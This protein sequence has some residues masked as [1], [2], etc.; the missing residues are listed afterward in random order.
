MGALMGS[1]REQATLFGPRKSLVG[2]I[3]QDPSAGIDL[4]AVVILNAGIIHR[5]GPHRMFVRLSRLL[6]GQRR[7]VVRF[8][9]SGI[10]DSEPRNDGLAP[11]E[12]ALADLR[13]VLDSLETTRQIK[14]VVLVGLCSGAD[15]SVIYGGSDPRVVGLVLIDPSVPRTWRYYAHHYG[16]RIFRLRSWLNFTT[17]RHPMWRQLKHSIGGAAEEPAAEPADFLQTREVRAFLQN[18]YQRVVNAGIEILAVF[19]GDRESQYNYRE[20]LLEAFPA[21]RFGTLLQLHY[22]EK[23]THTF[24]D[25]SDREALLRLIVEW[26]GARLRGRADAAAGAAVS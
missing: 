6:A 21:V 24:T 23:A 8:D 14:Q 7:T 22:Y 9:L 2:I 19:T 18:A 1:L 26:M 12:A 15:H 4:P 11:L 25:V 20:Q 17:G 3:A 16:R 13:E 5:V 10:G